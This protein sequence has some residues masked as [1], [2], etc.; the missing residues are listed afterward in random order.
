[1]N[2]V[3][4]SALCQNCNGRGSYE[5]R[6]ETEDEVSVS[7]KHCEACGGTGLDKGDGDID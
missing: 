7:W 3:A 6:E 5:V 2:D 1:M 4:N